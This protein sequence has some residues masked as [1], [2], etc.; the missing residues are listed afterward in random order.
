MCYQATP[1]AH[2]PLIQGD[3]KLVPAT[4]TPKTSSAVG[5][6]TLN[7]EE[8]EICIDSLRV[9]RCRD[10]GIGSLIDLS[11]IS[12]ELAGEKTNGIAIAWSSRALNEKPR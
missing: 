1:A 11:K 12:P 4:G 10:P 8:E 3:G 5:P 7:Q 9:G 2:E 6:T